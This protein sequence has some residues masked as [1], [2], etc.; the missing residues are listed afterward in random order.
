MSQ[1]TGKANSQDLYIQQGSGES[2][3]RE[4]VKLAEHRWG[5]RLVAA[6]ALGSL[7]HGGFSR[8][9]SDVDLGPVLSDPLQDGDAKAV[10]G[11]SNAVKASGAPLADRLSIFWGSLTT[12]SGAA[13]GGRFPPLDRLDLKQCGRLLAGRDI[14][15][16]L[17]SPTVRD[18]IVSGADFALKVLSTPEVT[19]ELRD[20]ATLVNAGVRMLTKVILF[21]VRFLFT[22]QTGQ[23][24][25]NAA[26]VEYFTAVETGPAADLARKGFTWR[27]EPPD[28]NDHT[29]VEILERGLLPLY[30]LF[31]DDYA[32]RLRDYGELDLVQTFQEWRQRLEERG[33]GQSEALLTPQSNDV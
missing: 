21:P 30:R 15:E 14:R 8:H 19:A 1:P 6:Y 24:G 27:E 3:L 20:P 32:V 22:A 17:P 4:A 33:V 18:L 31:L 29:I 28:P 25:R 13:P 7:A 12:L 26:A 9:V 11:L 16:Q 23:I 5:N 10:D 2:V